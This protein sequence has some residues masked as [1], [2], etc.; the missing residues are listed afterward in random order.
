MRAK[1]FALLPLAV[2]VLAYAGTEGASPKLADAIKD[3]DLTT[4][5]SLLKQH[6]D[7]NVPQSDG[8]TALDWAVRENNSDLVDRLLKAGADAKAANRYGVTALYLAC[9]NGSAPMIEKLLKAGADPNSAT[10]EGETALMTIARTGNVEAAKVLLA[11]GADVNAREQWRQQTALMWAVAE[12]HPDIAQVLIDHG[13]DVN[14]RQ[15]EWHWER[16][17]TKE[18]REKWMPL[19]GETPLLFAAR[20]GCVECGQVLVRAHADINAA[21]PNN[22]TP[23]VEALING[24]YDFAA[25]LIDAGADPNIADATGRTPLYAAVDDHTMPESNLP[26]PRVLDNKLTSLDII[27]MLLAHGANVN[28]Q[29]VKQTPYRTKVDRG[30]DTM[31]TTGTTPLLRAAKAGDV[32][33]IKTLL[34]KGAD[35]KLTTKFGMTPIMAAAGLGTKEEDTTGRRK[36]QPEAVES[37]QLFLNAGEDIN[38]IDRQGDTALHGAAQKGDDQVVQFLADHGAKLDIQDKKGRT[39]L[40]AANGLMGNGGFDGSRRDVHESTVAL[41]KKLMAQPEAKVSAPAAQ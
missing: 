31:L 35:P 18:P 39:P 1:F 34:A 17:V 25:F 14:A 13:A 11:H 6:V 23:M 40:D 41:L 37:I 36:T 9:V 20:Q 5:L 4:A 8:T 33:V 10:T 26:A 3:G 21:D 29:L 16:Q 15:I 19:G 24:H 12:S 7:V 2:G 38:A 28:A 32:E 22:I 30:A 27:N